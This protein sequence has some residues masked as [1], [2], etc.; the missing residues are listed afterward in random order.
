MKR[1][2][3][4]KNTATLEYDD[5]ICTG[6]RICIQVCPHGVFTMQNNKAFI[7]DKNLCME[8]GAC[9]L[10]CKPGAITVTRGVGCAAAV[11]NGYIHKKE[12]SCSCG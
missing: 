4:L 11:I 7:F 12:P 10:N 5:S 6:C 9:A 1:L 2:T 8:C 3:Y